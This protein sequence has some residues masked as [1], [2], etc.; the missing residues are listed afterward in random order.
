MK[1]CLVGCGSIAQSAHGPALQRLQK[2]GLIT[3]SACCDVDKERARSFCNQFGFGRYYDDHLQM[4]ELEQP[5]AVFSLLPVR[6]NAACAVSIL[7]HGCAMIMEKPPG[8][9]NTEADSIIRA[10]QAKNAYHAVLFNRRSMPLVLEAKRLL[11]GE[12]IEAISLEM[13]REGRRNEDFTTT[14]IHGIDCIRF[15]MDRDFEVLDFHYQEDQ[16][17]QNTNF[18]ISGWFSDNIHVDMRFLP[19]AGAVTERICIYTKGKQFYLNLPVWSGTTYV[20]GFDQPGT[21]TVAQNE[22]ILLQ[23]TGPELSGCQDGY[24]LN[25]FYDEDRIVLQEAISGRETQFSVADSLQS[26][27]VATAMRNRKKTYRKDLPDL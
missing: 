18:Y 11:E 17:A 4:L 26:V 24:V 14:A 22:S 15:L 2:E 27:D 21:L 3:L 7:E 8:I 1:V 13:C 5:D 10:A 9:N 20:P 16:Q 25:G 19:C 23:V 12:T 6:Y